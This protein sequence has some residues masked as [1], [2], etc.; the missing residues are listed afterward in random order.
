[1]SRTHKHKHF[2]QEVHSGMHTKGEK[3]LRYT[4]ENI[5]SFNKGDY[6]PWCVPDAWNKAAAIVWRDK[7]L[8]F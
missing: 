1:M 7:A 2:I 4:D 6:L 3:R 8:R 5:K